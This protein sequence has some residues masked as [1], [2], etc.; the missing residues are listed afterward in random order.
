[1][2]EPEPDYSTIP[3]GTPRPPVGRSIRASS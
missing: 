1:V 2:P 3:L